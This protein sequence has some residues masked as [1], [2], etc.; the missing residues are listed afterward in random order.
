MLSAYFETP[1]GSVTTQEQVGV[2]R[3]FDGN[4]L[5]GRAALAVARQWLYF[6]SLFSAK[7]WSHDPIFST[8]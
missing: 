2:L 1:G 7:V 3:S 4:F 8:E 6:Y 5:V